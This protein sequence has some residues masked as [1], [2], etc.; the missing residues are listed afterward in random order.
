MVWGVRTK[1]LIYSKQGRNAL[2][3]AT[4]LL[5]IVPFATGFIGLADLTHSPEPAPTVSFSFSYNEGGH[6]LTVVHESGSRL[7]G[8]SIRFETT[9]GR[10]LGVWQGP[11]DAGDS[12]TL[13]NVPADA[14]VQVVWYSEKRDVDIVLDEWDGPAVS[15]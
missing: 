3:V 14:T 13:L 10:H 12:I 4:A 8:D 7:A 6:E 1:E 5:L 2:I 9:D 15:A 11:I